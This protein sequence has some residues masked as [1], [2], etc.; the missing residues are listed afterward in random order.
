MPGRDG[1]GPMGTGRGTG[2]QMGG[3]FDAPGAC[4]TAY[5]RGCN[6]HRRLR[7]GTCR[8]SSATDRNALTAE[9][10][11]LENRLKMID[12]KLNDASGKSTDR[13]NE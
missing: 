3:C 6:F 4:R 5:G 2:R 12:R 11:F 10:E 13:P 8:Y 7:D 1:T 9:K